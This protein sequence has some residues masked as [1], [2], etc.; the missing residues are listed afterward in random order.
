[1]KRAIVGFVLVWAGLW[2]LAHRA[3]VARYDV[4]PWKLS[5]WAMYATPKPPVVV[6]AFSLSEDGLAI[7]D[8]RRMRPRVRHALDQFRVRRHALGKLAEP[9]QAG[10]AILNNHPELT[11]IVIMVQT[12]SLDPETALMTS[13]LDQYAYLP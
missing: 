5:G 8:E 3:L 10:A 6:A 9:N 4:N 11:A 12:Y 2:P 7:L 13:V 1:M